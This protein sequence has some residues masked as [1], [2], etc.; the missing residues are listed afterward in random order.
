MAVAVDPGV[1]A[2]QASAQLLATRPVVLRSVPP[3]HLVDGDTFDAAV[4]VSNTTEQAV[5]ATV[6]LTANGA[7]PTERTVHLEPHGEAR[8]SQPVTAHTG[9]VDLRYEART[10]EGVTRAESHV[11][12]QPR[13]RAVSAAVFGAIRS[14]LTLPVGISGPVL[15][16]ATL[17]LTLASHPYLGLEDSAAGLDDEAPDGV[18]GAVSSLLVWTALA[19]LRG[20]PG[21]H[22]W[23]AGE[24]RERGEGSARRLGQLQASGGWYGSWGPGDYANEYTSTYAL[25]ALLRARALGWAV[26]EGTIERLTAYLATEVERA[27][28]S[29]LSSW[30]VEQH[31]RA[32]RVLAE[33]GRRNEPRV[34]DLY[35]LRAR[36]PL[37]ASAELA[38]AMA[39]SDRRRDALLSDVSRAARTLV[40]HPEGPHGAVSGP[41]WFDSRTRTVASLLETSS[42]EPSLG[43]P[44]VYATL[45]LNNRVAP[46]GSWGSP[47]DTALALDALAT[48]VA[49]LTLSEDALDARVTLDGEALAPR[50]RDR[51]GVVFALPAE[52][53]AGR[54]GALRIASARVVHASLRARWWVPLGPTDTVARGHGV[55]LHR[56]YESETGAEL[57]Q[58]AHGRL[59]DLVRVRLFVYAEREPPAFL[60]LRDPLPGG[61]EPMDSQLQSTP[62]GTLDALLGR[63]P[64]DDFIDPRGFHARRS[65][66]VITHHGL[67]LGR[68][69]WA[70]DH[71]SSGLQEFTYGIRATTPGAFTVPPA[72]M[73]ALHDQETLA[74][75]AAS[76]LI[77]DP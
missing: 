17:T 21:P 62:E 37:Y 75:S 6:T 59:G 12:V 65:L 44:G 24:L 52:R 19:R 7:A 26:P 13:A 11:P 49:A 15:P 76:T 67:G 61:F 33:A 51:A 39:P 25:H 53:L 64:D 77:V 30:T 60:R 57:A 5:T 29:S 40:D 1:R 34:S 47:H 50:A 74:R 14:P 73:D 38:G 10:P 36:L 46:A 43:D 48:H 72:R 4:Y 9:T 42:L 70:F 18:E 2:G 71:L 55:S 32:L 16:G 41:W 35:D 3:T 63:G 28:A 8:V 68:A 27:S 58:R 20:V 69:S 66:G 45:L 56:V 23:S 22:R 54:P 31:A